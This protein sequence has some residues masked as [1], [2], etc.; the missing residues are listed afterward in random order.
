[1]P[2]WL[3]VSIFGLTIFVMLVG[4]FGLIVPLFPGIT[5]IWL[6][7][8]GYGIVVGFNTLGI[9]MFVLIT[10][11]MILGTT[12]DNILS[13]LGG[14]KGGASWLSLLI[15]TLAGVAGTVLLPPIGWLIA[16]PAVL[17]LVEYIKIRNIK[18]ALAAVGGMAAGWGLS[19]IIR[20][21]IGEVMI[22]LWFVWAVFH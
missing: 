12:I 15:C 21:A 14:R 18:K 5:V 9:V 22:V 20:L 10:L 1:M 16:A 8:L 2:P 11:L 7:A 3:D 19:F 13:W 4:L 6:A 17:L